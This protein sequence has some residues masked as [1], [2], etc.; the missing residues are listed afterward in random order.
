MLRRGR[1]IFIAATGTIHD[2]E[3]IGRQRW[4]DLNYVRDGVGGF[5]RGNF[6]I[7]ARYLWGMR[8]AF[9]DGDLEGSF[10]N[11]AFMVTAGI[12]FGR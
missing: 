3:F 2:D 10:R 11:R 6:M 4:S 5:E 9:Q 1:D 8:E 7:D 12:G